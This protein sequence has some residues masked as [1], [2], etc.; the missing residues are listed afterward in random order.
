MRDVSLFKKNKN[1]PGQNASEGNAC[2]ADV[3]K[4][5]GDLDVECRSG[6]AEVEPV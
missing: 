3:G 6:E 2:K 5:E 1:S 4:V